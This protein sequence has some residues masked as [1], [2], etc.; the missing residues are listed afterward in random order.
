M[1]T[2]LLYCYVCSFIVQYVILLSCRFVLLVLWLFFVL[3]GCFLSFLFLVIVLYVC[4]IVFLL[5]LLISC[6][7][8]FVL[9]YCTLPPGRNPIAVN[10]NNNIV[11]SELSSGMYCRVKWLPPS[12]RQYAP[13]KRRS[14]IILHGSTSQKTILN[15]I[16]A[17]VRSWNLSIVSVYRL[18]DCNRSPAE[19]NDCSSNL[20]VQTISET[21]PASYRMGSG[22]PFPWGKT[23]PGRDADHSPDLTPRTIMSR[24]YTSSPPCRQYG[25][26][27]TVILLLY[28][29]W[30]TRPSVF[31]GK[32]T[33]G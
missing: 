23:Q 22:S 11:C 16:L 3:Y 1:C 4:V 26:R 9:V 15:I 28:S 25:G 13:L 32:A 14:T 7:R 12:W 17:A 20:C 8:F 27:G 6:L 19:E 18:G 2:F 5:L 31:E 33:R 30:S 10:N 24:I 29:L 21:H